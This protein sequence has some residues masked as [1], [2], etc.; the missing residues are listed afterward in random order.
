M[1]QFQKYLSLLKIAMMSVMAIFAF[2]STVVEPSIIV[3]ENV[4]IPVGINKKIVFISD[5]HLGIYKG[6]DFLEKT[7]EIINRNNPDYVLIAGDLTL[8]LEK[9]SHE[10]LISY[11]L[12]FKKI[13]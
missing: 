7:I 9:P 4:H 2:Y 5:I 11:F 12:P 1:I 13:G 10:E 6:G 8:F 3:T